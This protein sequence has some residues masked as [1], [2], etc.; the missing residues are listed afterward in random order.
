MKRT[1]ILII[2]L[3]LCFSL[4]SGCDESY[5][6]LSTKP[7]EEQA[8]PDITDIIGNYG[9]DNN[10]ISDNIS[11]IIDKITE[12]PVYRYSYITCV[13]NGLA[14]TDTIYVTPDNMYIGDLGTVVAVKMNGIW[15]LGLDMDERI[16][17]KVEGIEYGNPVTIKTSDIVRL[18]M[19][20]ANEN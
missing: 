3:I 13:V 6:Y 1:I 9:N 20:S 4:L 8:M 12:E 7:T 15:N 17:I 14:S 11:G 2:A 16:R 18:G 19:D 5:T 10:L